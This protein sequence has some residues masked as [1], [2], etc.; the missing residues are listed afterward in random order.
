MTGD[1]R[2]V[3]PDG[4]TIPEALREPECPPQWRAEILARLD[5]LEPE[6]VEELD[7]IKADLG[8]PNVRTNRFTKAHAAL[9]MRL[10]G[11]VV[12]PAIFIRVDGP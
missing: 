8:I 1:P 12:G 11:E 4:T 2:S 9:V 10:I 5:A 6:A 3:A 7:R